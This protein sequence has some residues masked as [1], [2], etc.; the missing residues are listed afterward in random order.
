MVYTLALLTIAMLTV[1]AFDA[2]VWLRDLDSSPSPFPV[3]IIFGYAFPYIARLFDATRPFVRE[4]TPLVDP[5]T[6]CLPTCPLNCSAHGGRRGVAQKL[7]EPSTEGGAAHNSDTSR[8][9]EIKQQSVL[10]HTL[11]R[12]PN[13]AERRNSIY[14]DLN[15]TI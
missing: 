13:A 15:L 14:V 11:I 12:I 5:P 1:P 10:P 4:P 3:A 7:V 6:P 8:T 9:Q 2:D